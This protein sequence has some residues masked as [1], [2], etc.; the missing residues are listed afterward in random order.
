MVLSFGSVFICVLIIFFLYIYFVSILYANSK[1][2]LGKI[3]IIFVGVVILCLRALIPFNFPFSVTVPV[4]HGMTG[5]SGLFLLTEIHGF[6]LC[7]IFFFVWIVGSVIK[8]LNMTRKYFKFS[9]MIHQ[10]ASIDHVR[11]KQIYNVLEKYN[12]KNIEIAIL[13]V[14][15]SPAITGFKRPVLL[16]PDYAFFDA[17]LDYIICHEIA[18]YKK[19]DLILKLLL[20]ICTCVYWWNPIMYLFKSKFYLAVEIAND[21]SMIKDQSHIY[22]MNYI[23]CLLLNSK[24]QAGKRTSKFFSD[25]EIPFIKN[26]MYLK[27]RVKKILGYTKE[28]SFRGCELVSGIFL[29]ILLVIG[30]VII[31]E[32]YYAPE[33]IYNTTFDINADNSYFIETSK[34]F[35]LYT[36]GKY[37]A[38]FSYPDESFKALRIYKEKKE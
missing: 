32:A 28:G 20:E 21:I 1:L 23:K 29:G 34:G 22:Q 16:I 25:F 18:H 30:I 8:I 35:D 10:A 36:D 17:D 38:T 37:L 4:E 9:L 11:K 14:T 7:E 13:P 12:I 24:L 33:E 5:I 31:P 3:R 27:I 6:Y 15:M 2:F 19:F 26:N